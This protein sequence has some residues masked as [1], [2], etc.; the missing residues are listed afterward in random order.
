M[1]TKT[2]KFTAEDLQRMQSYP[3]QQKVLRSQAKIIEACMHCNWRIAVSFSGGKDSA[4][5]L[6][7]TARVWAINK[8]AHGDAPLTVVFANT[9]M[10]HAGM[11]RFV[12]EFCAYI[13]ETHG[14]AIDL[15]ITT[16]GKGNDFRSIV[17]QKRRCPHCD[18]TDHEILKRHKGVKKRQ[19]ARKCPH[20]GTEWIADFT[21]GYPIG[22]KKTAK[23]IRYVREWVEQSGVDWPEF[24]RTLGRDEKTVFRLRGMGCPDGTIL[25]LTGI[26][27]ELKRSNG[28]FLARTWWPLCGPDAPPV[29][30]VCCDIIKKAPIHA[31]ENELGLSSMVATTAA[32]SRQRKFSWMESGCNA[33]EGDKVRSK[34]MSPWLEQDVL[35]YHD[36]YRLP[37]F[38]M[39]GDLARLLNGNLQFTGEQRT[40]C[41]LCMFGCQFPD[42][43]DR[44]VRLQASEPHT[45]E[46]AMRPVE[47]G[48]CGLAEVLEFL[49]DRCGVEIEMPKTKD[50]LTV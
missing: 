5:L 38:C 16:P 2:Y 6:D 8:E 1:A 50:T 15:H 27:S 41:K 31:I 28:F 47:L 11:V 9:G 34:P 14:I 30:E 13:Q 48:G 39:Y 17:T 24:S 43:R 35:A 19:Q 20:C 21:L 26:N 23:A 32:E 36:H 33:F 37:H 46:W 12:R 40:G 49:H 45:V 22:S 42:E 7:M 4:V 44:L 3:W 29:S 18:S 10:E 25:Y